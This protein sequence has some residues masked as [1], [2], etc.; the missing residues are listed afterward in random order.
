MWIAEKCEKNT[1][2]QKLVQFLCAQ[3]LVNLMTV[4]QCG[5]MNNLTSTLYPPGYERPSSR[6]VTAISDGVPSVRLFTKAT[7]YEK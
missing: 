6:K 7:A 2:V 4:K 1:K 5:N 3:N